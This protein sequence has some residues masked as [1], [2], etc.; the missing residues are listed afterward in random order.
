M[1][2]L[3]QFDVFFKNVYFFFSSAKNADDKSK[4]DTIKKKCISHYAKAIEIYSNW[5]CPFDS[6]LIILKQIELNEFQ[7]NGM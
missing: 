1:F 3:I 4:F 7:M 6:L 2:V 5:N